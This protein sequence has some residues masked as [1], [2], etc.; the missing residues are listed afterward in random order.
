MSNDTQLKTFI[1]NSSI[2][3]WLSLYK[4]NKMVHDWSIQKQPKAR[5]F[6]GHLWTTA[7]VYSIIVQ[8]ILQL[9]SQRKLEKQSQKYKLINFFLFGLNYFNIRFSA[10]FNIF[11]TYASS[12]NLKHIW[13]CL[14]TSVHDPLNPLKILI[15]ISSFLKCLSVY[16]R[17]NDSRI[18]PGDIS[19]ENILK[20]DW[21][22]AFY[23]TTRERRFHQIPN[24]NRRLKCKLRFHFR[25]FSAKTNIFL[26]K[27]EKSNFG[28]RISSFHFG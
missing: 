3:H 20:F 6:T 27:I 10:S 21:P 7:S 9:E 5:N 1:S 2:P 25:W 14:G 18:P 23:A 13:L 8:R 12:C 17:Q 26:K 19:D 4:N 11:G 15:S 16:P 24:L 22:L 28:I